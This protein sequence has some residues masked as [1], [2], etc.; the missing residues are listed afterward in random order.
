MSKNRR[1][2]E[3]PKDYF[4]KVLSKLAVIA[5]AYCYT[6]YS[7]E[8]VDKIINIIRARDFKSYL[9]FCKCDVSLRKLS[10]EFPCSYI[11]GER[12][13]RE[14]RALR[15]LTIFQKYTFSG[16]N[17]DREQAAF[18]KFL[19][20]ELTCKAFNQETEI[21]KIGDTDSAFNDLFVYPLIEKMKYIIRIVCGKLNLSHIANQRRNGPGASIGC[22]G[23]RSTEVWK[24]VF[25]LT[26]NRS[27]STLATHLLCLD[28]RLQ[29]ASH[30]NM[31]NFSSYPYRIFKVSES[32]S[33]LSFV[34]KTAEIDRTISIEPTYNMSLQLAVADVLVPRLK[35]KLGID[36]STQGLN[37][38]LAKEGSKT[39]KLVT[40]DLEAASD[41]VSLSLLNLL[42]VKWAEVIFRIRSHRWNHPRYGNSV[43]H[44]ISSM[45]NGCTFLLESLI[46]TAACWAVYSQLN[47]P[48]NDETRAIYGDDII[49]HER[50]YEWTRILLKKLGFKIN[51]EK[52]FFTGPIRE[53]CGHDYYNGHRIDRFSVKNDLSLPFSNV[54][55]H[56]SLF[57]YLKRYRLYENCEE[58]LLYIRKYLPKEFEHFGPCTPDDLGS[59][60]FC[61]EPDQLPLF[62]HKGYQT[63]MYR[64]KRNEKT[65]PADIWMYK[66]DVMYSELCF[67]PE[68]PFAK[69]RAFEYYAPLTKDDW[70][71]GTVF[72]S[73]LS[74]TIGRSSLKSV[75]DIDQRVDVVRSTFSIKKVDVMRRTTAILPKYNWVVRHE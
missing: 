46:F 27:A 39:G 16:Y 50:A 52:S 54:I 72:Q 45:G 7:R 1:V 8:C 38:R 71:L 17:P 41:S 65:H 5:N 70:L 37:Q 10:T 2:T 47:I 60:L 44:K 57:L 19:N 22:H 9:Q 13:L 68:L 64:L 42:P 18:E 29:L 31:D 3:L 40:I 51:Q 28:S 69:W 14:I 35:K 24:N 25:P 74:K 32:G 23:N 36:L 55:L 48:W 58:L 20:A 61:E 53:S 43:F 34:P 56:N 73:N 63:W 49:V 33:E 67:D 59:W 62:Y 12:T 66:R 6:P 21:F 4:W 15:L 30:E 75:L 11:V 26:S